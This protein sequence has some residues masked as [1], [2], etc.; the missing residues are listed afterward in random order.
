MGKNP[1]LIMS[2]LRHSVRRRIILGGIIEFILILGAVLGGFRYLE[3][4]DSRGGK[5]RAK[6]GERKRDRRNVRK[7]GKE[8]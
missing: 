7:E 6:T 3:K 4:K 2:G 1:S 8:G 5:E